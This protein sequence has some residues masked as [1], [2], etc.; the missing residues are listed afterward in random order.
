MFLRR[1]PL[2][3]II[4]SFCIAPFLQTWE[5]IV[6]LA[7]ASLHVFL[8]RSFRERKRLEA[9]KARL[10][11][12]LL[13]FAFLCRLGL[14]LPRVLRFMKGVFSDGLMSGVVQNALHYVY[15][16]QGLAGA[17]DGVE[18]VEREVGKMLLEIWTI[19]KTE[20]PFTILRTVGR[21]HKKTLIAQAESLESKRALSK[22]AAFFLPILLTPLVSPNF[23]IWDAMFTTLLALIVYRILS[24][25][26]GW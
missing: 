10:P 20:H 3:Y 5:S 4:A 7:F 16:G 25:I 26:V 24:Y 13:I 6:L 12:N 19:G 1:E 8:E 15:M 22:A 9:E 21:E 14:P 18:L 17:F 23:L 11:A 2:I